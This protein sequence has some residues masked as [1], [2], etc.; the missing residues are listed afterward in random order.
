VQRDFEAAG[1]DRL[2]VADITY[3]PTRAGFVYLAVVLDAWSRKVVGWAMAPHLRIA[4][5]ECELLDR[6]TLCTHAE[7]HVAVFEFIESWYDPL[8][9][10]SALDYRSPIEF[11]ADPPRAR[12]GARFELAHGENGLRGWAVIDDLDRVR[13]ETRVDARAVPGLRPVPGSFEPVARKAFIEGGTG[14][15]T[16]RDR[17]T[18]AQETV[19]ES[20]QLSTESGQVH[21]IR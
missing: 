13:P 9:R 17:K 3:V 20:A 12:L 11:R 21:S 5:L 18:C 14:K 4:T 16:Q 10:H 6:Q 1:P 8:R 7:A 2:W 15:E 19:S